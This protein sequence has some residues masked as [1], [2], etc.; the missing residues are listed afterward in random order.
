MI[1]RGLLVAILLVPFLCVAAAAGDWILRRNRGST[2]VRR[3]RD[4]FMVVAL[5]VVTGTLAYHIVGNWQRLWVLEI[6]GMWGCVALVLLIIACYLW[7]GEISWLIARKRLHCKTTKCQ[8]ADLGTHGS[9]P[10]VGFPSEK[11]NDTGI[12]WRDKRRRRSSEEADCQTDNHL[13]DGKCGTS[14]R[15]W[16]GFLGGLSLLGCFA[17]WFEND[18][19]SSLM[20]WSPIV[21]VLA[22]TMPLGAG[23]VLGNLLPLRVTILLSAVSATAVVVL[24]V[25]R[26]LN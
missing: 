15:T 18:I 13:P 14:L 7:G 19:T 6:I 24:I 25:L 1:S 22:V 16:M 4:S 26:V 23:V 2:W 17:M 11:L 20:D 10:S 12:A 9:G 3:V 5:L 8:H 21:A